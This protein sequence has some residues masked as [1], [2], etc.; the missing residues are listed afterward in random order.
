MFFFCILFSLCE[1]LYCYWNLVVIERQIMLKMEANLIFIILFQYLITV[2]TLSQQSL[3][4]P[5]ND[6]DQNS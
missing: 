3:V 6:A 5:V 4:W 2:G 1:A